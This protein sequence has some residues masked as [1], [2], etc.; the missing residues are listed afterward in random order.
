MVQ[1]QQQNSERFGIFYLKNC[2]ASS[3]NEQHLKK[4]G[5]FSEQDCVN[6][7]YVAEV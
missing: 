4:C 2:F 3:S 6:S 5:S 7:G 1:E